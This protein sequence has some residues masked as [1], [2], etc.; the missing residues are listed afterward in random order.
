VLD[1]RQKSKSLAGEIIRS[2]REQ[3]NM[4]QDTLATKALFSRTILSQIERGEIE[5][6]RDLL[7]SL[8]TALDIKMLPLH[9]DERDDFRQM[10]RQWHNLID[11][12][13]LDEALK[14]HE[15]LSIIKTIP[16][17]KE[18]NTLFSL[19][20]CKLFLRRNKL[21]VAKD[22]LDELEVTRDD[23]SDIQL[24]HYYYNLG[25]YNLKSR[26]YRAAL[27]ANLK[28]FEFI[29]GG[30][31]K[32]VMFFYNT[33]ICYE[34]LGFVMLAIAFLEKALELY[35]SG[36]KNMSARILYN[37]LG[38]YYANVGHL[39][40]AHKHLHKAHSIAEKDYKE[41]PNH[42]TK[43]Y[44]GMALLNLGFMFRRA[45]QWRDAVECI[46]KAMPYLKDGSEFYLEALYEKVF[47][48]IQKGDA[49][50][51]ADMIKDGLRMSKG[52]ELYTIMFQS[53]DRL[54]S[55][56]EASVKFFEEKAIPY[57]IKNNIYAYVLDYGAIVKEY[58]KK[59]K[60][61]TKT[62]FSE[63]SIAMCNVLEKMQKGG[64][65]V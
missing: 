27:D 36:Q 25:T 37:A 24:Y 55:V 63:A 4:S 12:Y 57:F 9:E 43:K 38:V 51:C 26:Q 58:F 35:K 13:K 40:K 32:N 8:K 42:E 47:S 50:E 28:A 33:A 48:M 59:S 2:I 52:M 29:K 54:V 19:F 56:D 23:F 31:E 11:E 44:V 7:N 6:P 3:K 21:D 18:L 49:L 46:D 10:L 65:I 60:R 34:R 62:R 64:I 41:N 15:E 5:C 1:I 30:I 22:M 61:N 53:L 20:E 39:P 45:G 17:D 16:H 14:K